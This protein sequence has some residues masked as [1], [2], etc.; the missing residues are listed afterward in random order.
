MNRGKPDAMADEIIRLYDRL[1]SS[2]LVGLELGISGTSVLR[3]LNAHGVY[4]IRQPGKRSDEQRFMD[5]VKVSEK[6]GCWL[7]QG[8]IHHGYAWFRAR[9]EAMLHAHRF[10]YEHFKGPIPD[11]LEIDHLCRA[12]ACVN[13]DHLEAVTHRENLIRM[14]RARKLEREIERVDSQR[15]ETE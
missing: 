6:T 1:K 13:P 2:R 9:G 12:R 8:R 3:V 5:L 7:W 15:G 10:S 4:L 11:G 14:Q